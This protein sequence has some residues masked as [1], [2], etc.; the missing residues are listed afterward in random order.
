MSDI[1]LTRGHIARH[2]PR[3]AGAQG[4]DAAIVDIA[5]DL[6]LRDLHARGVL[7][8]LA[9]KGG[10]AIRKLYAGNAGRFS[11]D[12]DFSTVPIGEDPDDALTG[13]IAAID[14]LEVGPFRYSVTERRGKWTLGYEHP[15]GG[16]AL[17]SKLDLNPPPWLEPTARGW[18]PLP[19]HAQYGA[20]RLPELQVVRLEENIAE[21]IARLNRAT[22]ARDMYD[23]RWAI[24][25]PA[26]A[27]SL[28]LTLIR[29]LA[30]LKI[31]V[32]ANGAHAGNTWWKP[33]HEG[34][35]FDPDRWLRDRSHGEFDEEDIGAL[36]VPVP[37]AAELS[38]ALRTHFGFLADLDPD[39]QILAAA[40]EQDRP[41]ALRL[42]AS[43]PGAR[44]SGVGLY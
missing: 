43:L 19:V 30:V 34:P 31:W 10:T 17:H 16:Q 21:K 42:L 18:Q 2:T 32:D 1:L 24:T 41:L 26:I 20:P 25:T 5:Q 36:A 11:L 35:A 9:F 3:G 22:P 37:T 29:R 6:L 40:R 38:E 13:L 27:R 33:G 44:L 8:P 23:L 4:Q 7:D 15:F 14:G 39:E 12:L 28:D